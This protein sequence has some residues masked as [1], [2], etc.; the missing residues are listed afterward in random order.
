MQGRIFNGSN[1]I[2]DGHVHSEEI[3]IV[4]KQFEI[5]RDIVSLLIFTTT[6]SLFLV[7]LQPQ[8]GTTFL[9]TASSKLWPEKHVQPSVPLFVFLLEKLWMTFSSRQ[10]VNYLLQSFGAD[11]SRAFLPGGNSQTQP[12]YYFLQRSKTKAAF[13]REGDRNCRIVP[14]QRLC[15]LLE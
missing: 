10:R 2:L 12:L 6:L 8:A 7:V 15:D 4:S 9:L 3:V 13:S 14:R 1:M 5:E 11:Q